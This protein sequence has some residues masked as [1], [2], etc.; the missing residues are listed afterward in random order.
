MKMIYLVVCLLSLQV[1]QKCMTCC[2]EHVCLVSSKLGLVSTEKSAVI[3]VKDVQ[4]PH[5]SES[6]RVYNT[7]THLHMYIYVKT[8]H[9]VSFLVKT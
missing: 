5:N 3:K 7:S 9:A 4:N 8:V 1:T 2:V 6:E